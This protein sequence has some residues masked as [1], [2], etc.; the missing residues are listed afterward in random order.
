MNLKGCIVMSPEG[1]YCPSGDFFCRSRPACPARTDHP[2]SFRSRKGRPSAWCSPPERRSPSWRCVTGLSFANRRSRF[3][4]ASAS[5][6]AMQTSAFILLGMFWARPRSGSAFPARRSSYQATTSGRRIRPAR[7]S[8]VVPCDVFITEAT[9]G[10]PVFRHSRTD[11][12]IDKLLASCRLF[13]ERAHLVG[14]YSLGKAQRV[15][16]LLRHGRPTTGLS[17][18]MARSSA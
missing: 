10:L 12:E 2:R 8:S 11:L 9:F 1:L 16:A 17:T 7:L 13:P 3:C 6:W 5:S 18:S 15:M 4:G 14:A